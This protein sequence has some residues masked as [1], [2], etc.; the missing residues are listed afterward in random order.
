[1]PTKHYLVCWSQY[2]AKDIGVIESVKRQAAKFAF[3]NHER[4]SSQCYLFFH[5]FLKTR[6]SKEVKKNFWNF[7][8]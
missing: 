3:N 7:L 6:K 8:L 2:T 5:F 4:T 1:M